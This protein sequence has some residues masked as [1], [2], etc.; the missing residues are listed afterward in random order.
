V[1]NR[2]LL[3][4]VIL[5]GLVSMFVYRISNNV[6]DVD[7]W[8]E[9]SLARETLAAGR[10][11]LEDHFAYMPTKYPVV[12]HE[13]GAGI[14]AYCLTSALGDAGIV[15]AKLLLALGLGAVCWLCASRRGTDFAVLTF[16]AAVAVLLADQGF[17]TIRA[18]MYSYLFTA[19]LLYWMDRDR[20]GHRRWLAAWLM[21]YVVWLNV[22]AGFLVGAGLFAVYWLEQLVRKQ[23]HFHLLLAGLAMIPLMAVN[24]Y[25]VHYY[26]YLWNSAMMPRPLIDE[27]GP[28]WRNGAFHQIA[29]FVLSLSLLAY[30]VRHVGIRAFRGLPVI[31][32][33]ALFAVKS[34]RLLSFY[35]VAW[36]C[37][38]PAYLQATPL[39][40]GL[41][42][43]Y[44]ARAWPLL[45]IWGVM[46]AFCLPSLFVT[47]PWLLRIPDRQIPKFGT[48]VIYPVGAVDYL[49]STGF[50]G[51]LMVPFDWG[52][53]VSWRLYPEVKV[54]I[55]SR[56]EVAYPPGSLEENSAFYLAQKGWQRVLAIRPAAA[57][58]VPT[59]LPVSR[60]M[61]SVPGWKRVYRDDHAEVYVRTS[62]LAR[63]AEAAAPSP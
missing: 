1:L 41:R 20:E 58:L 8:H 18:Q 59:T 9:M 55:D 50:R 36:V 31:L 42:R 32:I 7:L 29:V 33:C 63:A 3:P 39:G 48:H 30:T 44:E 22:H 16:L 62:D 57:V 23:P 13:W 2:Y 14:V 60:E 27:W 56:Y 17:S 24:P 46:L 11:P 40:Q 15:A 28:L 6:A 47:K 43:R 10:V 53:Y 21:L 45:A 61:P 5:A 4:G 34:T 26:E 51:N 19:C 49:A 12:H 25:G 52:A 37:Y 35:A 54:S 38:L